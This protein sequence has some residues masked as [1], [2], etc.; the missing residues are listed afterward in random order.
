MK[1]M[2]PAHSPVYLRVLLLGSGG[3]L[4]TELAAEVRRRKWSLTAPRRA[5]FDPMREL[6]RIRLL[7]R[8]LGDFDWV[9]NA[10]GFTDVDA[11][12]TRPAEAMA[13]NALLP[14]A[15]A[16]ACGQTGW[17]LLTVSTDYVF[18]GQ[19]E[20]PYSEDD[21]PNPLSVYGRSKLMG[22]QNVLRTLP[23]SLVVRTS[24]LFGAGGRSFPGTVLQAAR[25]GRELRVVDDQFGRPTSAVDLARSLCDAA[26]LGLSGLFHIAGPEAMSWHGLAVAVLAAESRRSGSP[27]P[28][29]VP[30]GTAAY[31]RA[32]HRPPNSVLDCGKALAAGVPPMR[33][34]AES[35]DEF[36]RSV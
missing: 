9:V 19:H 31:P 28:T 25:E 29:V 33:P 17:R 10:A 16:A 11:A 3:L 27:P 35:L 1:G 34:L 2:E 22:E 21:Q 8:D 4:G 26:A 30:V 5:E 14:G 32:A 23:G 15:L 12:E 13:G 18:D 20:N 6:D 7:R 36:V 24:W